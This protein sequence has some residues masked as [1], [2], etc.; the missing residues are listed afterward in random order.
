MSERDK[1]RL[2]K[3]DEF[4]NFSNAQPH[5]NNSHEFGKTIADRSTGLKHPRD[6]ANDTECNFK[7]T[8]QYKPSFLS[9]KRFD[10]GSNF[11]RQRLLL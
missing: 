4:V 5:I 10:I 2:N 6:D 1:A 11:T 3:F 9:L 8:T 7:G